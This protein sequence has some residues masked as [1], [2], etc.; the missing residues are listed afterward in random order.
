[1]KDDGKLNPKWITKTKKYFV[2]FLHATNFPMPMKSG[3]TGHEYLYPEWMI[4]FISILAVK[5]KIK[6]YMGI[7]RMTEEYWPL[8]KDKADLPAISERQLRDRLKKI[9]FKFRKPPAF[10]FQIFPRDYLE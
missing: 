4:M 2:E 5:C 7:H 9:S 10:I 8:I 1:M 3:K 6:T